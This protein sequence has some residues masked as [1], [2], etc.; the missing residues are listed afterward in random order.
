MK[1]SNGRDATPAQFLEYLRKRSGIE[2][3]RHKRDELGWRWKP[4]AMFWT[5]RHHWFLWV[6]AAG[7]VTTTAVA[8]AADIK[9][10]F[11]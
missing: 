5:L 7:A 9:S 3:A 2:H 6:S 1:A 8:F 10:L 4:S 11:G